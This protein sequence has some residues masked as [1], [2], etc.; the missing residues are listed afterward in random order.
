[1]HIEFIIKIILSYAF[2]SAWESW[3]HQHILH[4]SV[5]RKNFWSSW[6]LFGILLK[7]VRFN[8][9]VMHH[10]IVYENSHAAKLALALLSPNSQKQLISTKWG[11][12]VR[13]TPESL[14]L[15]CAV[16]IFSIWFLTTS[17]PPLERCIC[18]LIGFVPYL[19]TKYLHPI[20]HEPISQVVPLRRRGCL[21]GLALN[22]VDLIARYHREHH[23]T[24][25]KN[26]NLML[27]ADFVFFVFQKKKMTPR[28]NKP[29]E[30]KA[31]FENEQ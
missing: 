19:L 6:G 16:P 5:A 18:L 22:L 9:H 12:T 13:T 30:R 11:R 2:T 7:R 15:F 31:E 3:A 25:H 26:F 28:P 4:A 23:I 8:H 29:V 27:G 14:L 1:M 24:P 17:L 10:R 21:S 20:L